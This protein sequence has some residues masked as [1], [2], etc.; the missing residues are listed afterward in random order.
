M[1]FLSLSLLNIFVLHLKLCLETLKQEYNYLVSGVAMIR[2]E[3]SY[4]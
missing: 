4:V 2:D 1:S 3:I